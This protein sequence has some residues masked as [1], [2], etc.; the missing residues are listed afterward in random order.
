MDN[1]S[2]FELRIAS[3]SPAKVVFLDI[4][5]YLIIVWNTQLNLQWLLN[6]T[7]S[8]FVFVITTHSSVWSTSSW[9][10][11]Y[12]QYPVTE[13]SR[14]AMTL[15]SFNK[16]L[17]KYA[18]IAILLRASWRTHDIGEWD[19]FWCWKCKKINSFWK[20]YDFQNVVG[21]CKPSLS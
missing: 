18:T 3:P 4:L 10:L 19:R 7:F 2:Y 21:W 9:E 6:P 12:L 16:L 1:A 14:K 17:L 5:I 15:T 13:W 8:Y 20:Q 11:D